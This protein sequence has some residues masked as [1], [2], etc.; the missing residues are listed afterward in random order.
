MDPLPGCEKWLLG[1]GPREKGGEANTPS[2]V[3][4]HSRSIPLPLLAGMS[5]CV[6]VRLSSCVCLPVA[7]GMSCCATNSVVSPLHRSLLS[8]T[9]IHCCHCCPPVLLRALSTSR[10]LLNRCLCLMPL[11]PLLCSCFHQVRSFHVTIDRTSSPPLLKCPQKVHIRS[12]V[13][14]CTRACRRL[15]L[16]Q[17][18]QHSPGLLLMCS[19]CRR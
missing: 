6:G 4:C 14:S 1:V 3:T 2:Q 9:C 18:A 17:S 7:H 13:W 5:A 11:L 10:L 16:F 8:A 19:I 15:L 12:S